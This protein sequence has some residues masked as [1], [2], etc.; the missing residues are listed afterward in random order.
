VDLENYKQLLHYNPRFSQ[1]R[2]EQTHERK[3]NKK[4]PK[5]QSIKEILN[6]FSS[7]NKLILGKNSSHSY[8]SDFIK[9]FYGFLSPK[10]KS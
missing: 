6:K 1:R 7:L 10:T 3:A 8:S 5:E 9:P 2:N 4:M